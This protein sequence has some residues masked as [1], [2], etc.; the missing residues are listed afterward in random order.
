[1]AKQKTEQSEIITLGSATAPVRIAFVHVD[2]PKKFNDAA[3]ATA[4]YQLTSLI[5]P[6]NAEHA[7]TLSNLKAE[8]V[9]LA[10][11]A[12]G[13]PLPAE[14]RDGSKVCLQ[15]NTMTDGS[16]RK[17][18]DGYKGMYYL[19]S[20]ND[21]KPIVVNRNA[22][23]VLPGDPQYPQGGNL[24]IVKIRLWAQ[25]NKYGKRINANL[26]LV[27]FVKDDGVR[28][29]GGGAVTLPEGEVQALGDDPE[30]VAAGSI[31]EVDDI[32]F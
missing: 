26:L 27:Q 32:T 21:A 11:R 10:K 20:G 1:M 2:Q 19:P 18:Y 22:Q 29:G 25:N 15:N 23:E 16:Q 31:K 7:K 3:D 8:I 6:E 13:E 14:I 28:F 30:A 24:A 4:K 9:K 17:E 5:N 12:Y